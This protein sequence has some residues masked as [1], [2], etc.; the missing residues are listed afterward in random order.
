METTRTILNDLIRT[1]TVQY[2]AQ[3]QG[4]NALKPKQRELLLDGFIDGVRTGVTHTVQMLGV[5]VKD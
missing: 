5:E 3:L 4:F 1:L 2:E